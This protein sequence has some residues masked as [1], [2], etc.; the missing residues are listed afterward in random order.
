[1]KIL[2]VPRNAAADLECGIRKADRRWDGHVVTRWWAAPELGR[3]CHQKSGWIGSQI[4]VKGEG[5]YMKAWVKGGQ[6][7]ME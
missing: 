2:K 5:R 3:P 7:R 6:F 1:M 4:R